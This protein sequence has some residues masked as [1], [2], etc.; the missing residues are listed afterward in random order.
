[1]KLPHS[2]STD[3]RLPKR[4]LPADIESEWQAIWR[5]PEVYRAVYKF[6]TGDRDRPVFAIDTPP[7]FTSGEM[8]MGQAYWCTINDTIARYK[9]MRGFN[10]LLPQGWDCQG[11]P[12]ELKV[13]YK[14]GVSREDRDAFRSKCVEWTELMIDSMKATMGR[15]GYRPDWEQFEYRTM[16]PS[17][18]RNVQR[19]LL[20]FLAE[21]LV[22]RAAFPVHWCTHCETA[23]AQAELGYVEEEGT[24]YYVAFPLGND[25]ALEL[26]TSRP[27]LLPACQAVAVHP[28]DDRY[29][30]LIGKEA[31]VPLFGREVPVL[32]DRDVDMAFGTGVVM[33]CTFGDEQDVRWQQKYALP[34]T[35]VLD[36]RGV[37][38]NAG[39]YDGL[40]VAEARKAV[41]HDLR[42]A[43]L[44]VKTET[45]DHRV[46]A[47]TER[48]DC[49]TPV[50]FLSKNQFFIKSLPFREEVIN[51]CSGMKWVP[52]HMLHRLTDWV[53]S[54]EWD[55]LIS[56]QRIYGTPIPFW[57]CDACNEIIPP[58]EEQLPVDTTKLPSPV[59][60]CPRCGSPAI[61]P[62]TD[63]CDCWVD[64]SLTPL[65][66]SGYFE[67]APHF[68]RAYP[69]S[70]R[71]QGND[72]IRTWLYYSTLRC[73]LL[74]RRPP[75]REAL[76]NG[77]VLGPDGTNMSKSR[78][79]VIKPEEHLAEFGADALRQV[80]L[81][82]TIG[83]DFPF[84]WEVVKYSKAFLQKYW[85][86]SRLAQP[87]LSGYAPSAGD[88]AHLARLDKWALAKLG[89]TV[90]M[91]THAL[92]N[93]EFHIALAAMQDFFWHVFCD[94]YLEAV[95]HRLYDKLNDDDYAA[96]RYTL[97]T[98]L[99]TSTLLL[100][101]ICP[102]IVEEINRTIFKNHP[103]SIHALG[104]P[105]VGAIPV[106]RTDE[107][108]G[109]T[110]V[111][112]LATIRSAKARAGIPLSADV[113]RI[114][115][116]TPSKQ[117][118]AVRAEEEEIKKVLHVQSIAYAI[119]DDIKV[120][121][122]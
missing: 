67:D 28:D 75:F 97:Y 65:I 45:V 10:V 59:A 70:V 46:L 82:P 101:P 60:E 50:E 39:R 92:D 20:R 7:P 44:L 103:R 23:L 79:N 68:R 107:E 24:L 63:V 102:H 29:R 19:S 113:T 94:Q 95:K 73:W 40:T 88:D 62:T 17:Y 90:E 52:E 30:T 58:R 66:I 1:M 3:T 48:A 4:Y 112:V 119:G 122:G 99:W 9:R 13:Q 121:I 22:Y 53:N 72:I 74:T 111:A 93:Y 16:D 26:A 76:I 110:I 56:R 21:D 91:M 5:D 81:A 115:I 2:G 108:T 120:E 14:W 41:V 36:E 6:D 84:K 64:S 12:T 89:G 35:K 105:R 11:L 80:L 47:H 27:E 117:Q 61:H 51:A 54:T 98:V 37:M 104:W 100:A 78:G 71:Q 86:A 116:H 15:L 31:A 34:V 42:E 69:N 8:H 106:D 43:G 25:G 85:S 18:W 38:V 55:W 77:M 32:S 49:N 33:I 96:A 83:S 57:Y 87:F 118:P 109:D 114:T